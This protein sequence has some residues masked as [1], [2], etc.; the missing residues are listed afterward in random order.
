MDSVF[1]KIALLGLMGLGM[2]IVMYLLYINGWMILSFKSAVSFA[3]SR[4]GKSASFTGCSGS[5]R[6]IVRFSGDGVYTFA[7]ESVLSKGSMRVTL[8]DPD[9]REI[10]CLS[11]EQPRGTVVLERKKRYRLVLRFRSATGRYGLRWDKAAEQ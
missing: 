7:L 9:K 11:S 5:I 4:G 10:L 6:R 2:G 8:L 1:G 3:G